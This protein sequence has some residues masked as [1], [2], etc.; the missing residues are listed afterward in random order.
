M[1]FVSSF[2]AFVVSLFLV[3][4]WTSWRRSERHVATPK[5]G[6]HAPTCGF[7][8]SVFWSR[9]LLNRNWK[10]PRNDPVQSEK[11]QQR[12]AIPF[13]AVWNLATRDTKLFA[14]RKWIKVGLWL[15][16]KLSTQLF[17]T[18]MFVS[19]FLAFVIS[20]F[21]VNFW[22]SWRRSWASCRNPKT[23]VATRSNVW[24]WRVRFWSR[25]LL[26]QNWKQPRNGPV[27]SEK[28]QRVA[29]PFLAVWN[30]ATRDTKLFAWC[31][32]IKVGLWL[33]SKLSTQLERNHFLESKKLM[34]LRPE[35]EIAAVTFFAK[36]STAFNKPQ[37]FSSPTEWQDP[38]EH[39]C[40]F[41]VSSPACM[42][43]IFAKAPCCLEFFGCCCRR[44]SQHGDGWGADSA[45]T[46]L[47]GCFFL[48]LRWQWI[49]LS[50][51][52]VALL[53]FVLVFW[54]VVC[55]WTPP[56]FAPLES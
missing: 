6:C 18:W 15:S 20:L 49:V 13:F 17:S 27:Q 42:L 28:R 39:R 51:L 19:S 21:L 26:K 55:F 37:C 22:S 53:S 33:S 52:G 48:R 23:R 35:N 30:L 40:W 56:P 11:R 5:P 14:W 43:P 1:E 34:C 9:L 45:A 41:K 46:L 24:I 44:L 25:L 54:C 38:G 31:K 29:I 50:R 8:A 7:G 36:T 32:W 47:A 10:Q 16:S 2:L 3:N 12:V 4:F